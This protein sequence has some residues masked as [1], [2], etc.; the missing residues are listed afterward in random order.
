MAAIDQATVAH[1]EQICLENY[2]GNV[3]KELQRVGRELFTTNFVANDILKISA[4]GARN[5]ITAWAKHGVVAQ[6]GTVIVPPATRPTHLYAVIDPCAVRLMHRVVPFEK[7]VRDR[8]LPCGHCIT[9]NLINIDLYP[10][11]EDPICRQ[12]GRKL[13]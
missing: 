4:N 13:L 7:F 2:G 1:S 6:V 3:L 12:C 9:D 8:W 10:E 11:G 5:K